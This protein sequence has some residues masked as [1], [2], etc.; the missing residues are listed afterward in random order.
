[1]SRKPAAAIGVIPGN[2]GERPEPPDDLNGRQAAIWKETVASEPSDFFE[3]AATRALLSDYCRH[4]EAA[5]ILS[6]TIDSFLPEWIRSEDGGKAYTMFLRGRSA[7]TRAAVYLATKL[8]LT[9]QSRMRAE[10]AATAGRHSSKGVRPW[11]T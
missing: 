1:M 4:R 10:R 8:R 2:F 6:A 11:E 3:T 9:N 7:E 5:E